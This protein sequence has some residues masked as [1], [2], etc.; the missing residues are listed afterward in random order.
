MSVRSCQGPEAQP[1]SSEVLHMDQ[2]AGRDVG[3]TLLRRMLILFPFALHLREV[4]LPTSGTSWARFLQLQC[5]F[6][7]LCEDRRRK[8]DISVL[9]A[10]SCWSQK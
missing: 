2:K 8:N 10:P 4:M 7:S 9:L 6:A 5:T 1:V 3:L